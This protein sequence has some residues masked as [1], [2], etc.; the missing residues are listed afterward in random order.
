MI[1]TV[2]LPLSHEPEVLFGLRFSDLLWLM[3]AAAADV[4]I[5]RGLR[6]WPDLRVA[7]L[8]TI[9]GIGVVLAVARVEDA[10]LPAWIAR[11][12]RFW[13]TPRLFLP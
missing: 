1:R 7:C 10:S 4:G 12:V 3:G 11:G 6:L 13:V 9:S 8:G 5:W 2:F